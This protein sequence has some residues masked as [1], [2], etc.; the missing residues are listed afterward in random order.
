[1]GILDDL[2]IKVEEIRE[3]QLKRDLEL[4]VQEKYYREQLRP[5]MLQA[6]R[7]LSDIVHKLNIIQPEIR[8]SYPLNPLT[9]ELVTFDQ[10]DHRIDSDGETNP[11][12]IDVTCSCTLDQQQEF[13]VPG[14][15]AA[16]NYAEL[17][18]SYNFYH[19]RKN[20]LDSRF[21]MCG[22]TFFLEGPMH[23][24]I[25]ILANAT[26][27]CMQIILQNFE[28][29]PIKRY[30]FSPDKFTP[31]L[32]ERLARL[33][34]REEMLLVEVAISHDYRDQLRRQLEEE[35]QHK[36][37]DLATAFAELE[38]QRAEER[39][40]AKLLNRAKRRVA[41]WLELTK[42]FIR[43]YRKWFITKLGRRNNH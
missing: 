29:L 16:L 2:N 30:K 40:N 9:K 23:A 17:L 10:S 20:R 35:K 11:Y 15:D 14:K 1:M 31:D 24:R 12:Q 6:H 34:V 4:E 7:F 22:A 18:H 3:E 41:E 19:H 27:R 28:D 37:E 39:E 21:D 42:T 43:Q 33:L 8:P 38:S 32:L 5:L 26:D 25:R 36:E 13:Y